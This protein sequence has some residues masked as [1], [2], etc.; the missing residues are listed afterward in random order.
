MA[1]AAAALAAQGHNKVTKYVRYRRG[2][3]T[4]YG[5]LDGDTVRDLRGD[6]FGDLQSFGGIFAQG[7]LAFGYE[8][9]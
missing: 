6:L 3:S 2:T 5:I 9:G 8:W 4:A 7:Q 1:P